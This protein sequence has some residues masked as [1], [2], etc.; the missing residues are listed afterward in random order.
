MKKALVLGLLLLGL[1]VCAAAQSFSGSWNTDIVLSIDGTSDALTVENLTSILYVDYE[2]SGW[3]FGFNTFVNMDELFDINLDVAG[4]IGAFSFYSFLDFNPTLAT[5]A[6][7]DWEN[8]VA[9]NIAGAELWAA[10]V[11]QDVTGLGDIGTGWAVGAHGVAGLVEVWAEAD[12][13]LGSSMYYIYNYGWDYIH[14]W[15]SAYSCQSGWGSGWW[16]VQTE[17][18]TPAFSN[19]DIVVEA[20]LACLDFVVWVNFDCTNGFDYVTFGINDINLGAG[21]FQLDDL[22]VKFTAA[23][24]TVTTDFTLTFGSA[25][26]VTPYFDLNQVG[27]N[28]IDGITLQAL[29]LSY[30]YNGI[31]L[32][33]GELFPNSYYIGFNESGSLITSSYPNCIIP[34]ANEYVGIWFDGDS[35]CGGL[36]SAS[37]AVFFDGINGNATGDTS[38][39]TGIFDFLLM[40]ADVE[41]GIGSNFSLRAGLNVTDVGLDTISFGFG[42]QF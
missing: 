24:K 7:S 33:A 29:L 42:I 15:E 19:I 35:C 11:L 23:S 32:K 22:D 36:T 34:N 40:V 39:S 27:I 10:F 18:C 8:V 13:N 26:C 12:F 38:T 37:F 4:A 3:T 20:P 1:G 17:S 21:W 30:T 14:D 28:V 6:F 25:V 16:G 5:P 41:I 9:V 31:T 2:I